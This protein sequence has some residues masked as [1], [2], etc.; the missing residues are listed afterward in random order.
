[1][2]GC[3]ALTDD[4][5]VLCL[6]WLGS[7][8]RFRIRN[9]AL[10]YLSLC[11]GFRAS[12]ALSLNIADV[13]NG[14]QI[15]DEVYVQKKNVKGKTSGRKSPLSEDAKSCLLDYIK[16][17]SISK[18]KKTA[19]FRSN[20]GTRLGYVSMWKIYKKMF[21]DLC[22][23]G[24]LATHTSRKTFASKVF[25]VDKNV[26]SVKEGLGHTDL[27]TTNCYLSGND[28]DMK[29]AVEKMNFLDKEDVIRTS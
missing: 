8:G 26:L 29:K 6:N 18:P 20:I 23:I 19:L 13:W 25:E 21:D 24:K 14:K 11:S 28:K 1:M 7:H 22:M 16:T 3:R 9:K 5:I 4:E 12:E 15:V 10:F 17:L 2:K 27:R